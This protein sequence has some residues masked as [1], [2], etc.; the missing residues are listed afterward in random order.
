M[1]YFQ[2][3]FCIHECSYSLRIFVSK[4]RPAS[5]PL[6]VISALLCIENLPELELHIEL[7][8]MFVLE[9]LQSL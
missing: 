6:K 7:Q 2:E 8:V 4:V 1:Q 5:L 3:N 9:L